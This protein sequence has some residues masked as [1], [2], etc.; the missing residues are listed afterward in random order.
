M[1][2]IMG[3]HGSWERMVF[4]MSNKLMDLRKIPNYTE[5]LQIDPS[6]LVPGRFYLIQYDFNGNLIWCPILALDYKVHKNNHILYALNLEYLPPMYK[7]I[8]FN[9]IFKQTYV[10]LEKKSRN[11]FVRDEEPLTFMTFE[12][13]YKMLKKNGEMNWA[14]TAYTIINFDGKVKIKNAYLCSIKILPEIIFADM[15][16]FNVGEMLTLQKKLSGEEQ[17]K[18]SEIIEQYQKLIEEYQADSIQYHKNVALFR[19]KLKLFK[20]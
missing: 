5:I 3:L 2:G 18:M 7:V 9:M 19:E 12:F 14:I 4:E 11:E 8:F 6:K 13:I 17:V 1:W 10:E 15:K 16:R 20:D